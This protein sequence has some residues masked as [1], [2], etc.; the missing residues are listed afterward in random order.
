MAVDSS[1]LTTVTKEDTTPRPRDGATRRDK[2]D[3]EPHA[4]KISSFKLEHIY[5]RMR[6]EEAE[7]H[8]CVAHL[9]LLS[10]VL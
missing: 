2:I 5:K 4:S 9:S 1:P 6:A 8:V 10:L 3:Y 7:H